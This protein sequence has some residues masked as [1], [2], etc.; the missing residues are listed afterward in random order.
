MK[1]EKFIYSFIFILISNITLAQPSND[2]P[3]NAIPLTVNTSCSLQ[4]NTTVNATASSVADPSC[5]GSSFLDVWFTVVVPANG[6]LIIDTQTGTGMMTDSGMAWYTG[7]CNSL[8]EIYCDDDSGTGLMSMISSNTLTPGDIIYVRFWRYSGTGTFNMC[9]MNPPTMPVCGDNPIAGDN[10]LNASPVC[11]LNGY[12]GNTSATYTATTGWSQLTNEFCSGLQN[13]SYIKFVADSSSIGFYVWQTSSQNGDGI[14]M[15]VYSSS[16]CGSGAVTSYSCYS[17][18]SPDV[19]PSYI[20]ASG[21]TP[22]NTYYIII[23]G[24]S[25]DVC[26]YVIGLSQGS[27]GIA[28]PAG[29]N[30]NSSNICLGES[31]N[32]TASGGDGNYDWT[33]SPNSSE[34]NSTNTAN[35]VATPTNVGTSIYVITTLSGPAACPNSNTD[36]AFVY[37]MTTPTAG[38]G[39]TDTICALSNSTVV[40]A[41]SN[42]SGTWTIQNGAGTLTGANTLT[43]TYQSVLADEGN[44]VILDFTV[45]GCGGF[46]ISHD[47]I[48]VLPRL[49][50][51]I[52]GNMSF[53]PSVGSTHLT[54]PDSLILDSVVWKMGTTTVANSFN[55][56]LSAG[57]YN[58][59]FWGE[60]SLCS[61]DTTIT[62]TTQQ[63]LV[64]ENDQYICQN[65]HTFTG[66][67][68]GG[69]SG[70]WSYA[71]NPTPPPTFS[72]NN[73]NNTVTFPFTGT[74]TL[75]YTE[76]TCQEDDTVVITWEDAPVYDLPSNI[77]ACPGQPAHLEVKDSLNM[78]S[79]SWGLSSQALDTLYTANLIA[80]TYNIHTTSLHNCPGDTTIIVTTITPV[81][82]VY[83]GAVDCNDSTVY[84]DQ[85]IGN[86]NGQWVCTNNQNVTFTPSNNITTTIV[87]PDFGDYTF[88]FTESTCNDD[89]TV[90][91][92]FR[93]DAY[94]DVIDYKICSGYNQEILSNI[95]LPEYISSIEWTSTNN[96]NILGTGNTYSTSTAGIYYCT[97]KGLCTSY[98]DSS[99][100]TVKT[101]ELNIPNTFSPNGDGS[102]DY[103]ELITEDLDFFESFDI[104][105]VNRWGNVVANFN[106][107]GFK[108]DGKD[109]GGNMV[110]TGV[111]FYS[112]NSITIENTEINRQGFIQVFSEK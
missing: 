89:D 106:T 5:A 111:Y 18:I 36:T 50:T 96:S 60:N 103:F 25:N 108:W 30:P 97:V 78:S 58:V 101:C 15:M 55:T 93:P 88:V 56:N 65:T 52:N 85:N 67:T 4:A 64:L 107:P 68:G 3:C 6:S 110:P 11:N 48:R 70:I 87:V 28:L 2:D 38:D 53:C 27:G 74:Y 69:G 34:L 57:T 59:T 76:S 66:N 63:V 9:V 47:T 37:V 81:Q 84:L 72:N 26:D 16:T 102:N 22:G 112:I 40:G 54:A 99:L 43:P 31:V 39:I 42:G 79:I 20:S 51:H 12:C 73:L 1:F 49:Y 19:N 35:V 62:I 14:Q 61:K 104:S 44:T 46:A 100:I 10:C 24:F 23:D 98:T 92:K 17:Q 86:P 13:D 90:T 8:T 109:K 105:I 21:L 80:G 45:T 95:F 83:S 7:D 41:T 33:T 77:L 29:I 94:V 82:I 71:N 91:I 32:L 75:V